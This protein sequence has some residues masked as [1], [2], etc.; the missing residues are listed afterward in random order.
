MGHQEG[1]EDPRRHTHQGGDPIQFGI[2]EFDFESNSE[3]R[4]ISPSN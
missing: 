2:L 1:V 4:T 3:P